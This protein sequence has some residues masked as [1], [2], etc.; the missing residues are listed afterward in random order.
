MAVLDLLWMLV[1]NLT[2]WDKLYVVNNEAS[3]LFQLL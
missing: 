2:L 1:A 3:H